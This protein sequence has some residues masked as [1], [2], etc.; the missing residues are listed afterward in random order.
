MQ[1]TKQVKAARAYVA[2]MPGVSRK[3]QIELCRA[4]AN[5]VGI[6]SKLVKIYGP[7]E[8][9]AFVG[10]LRNDEVAVAPDLIVINEKPAP[11]GRRLGVT[12]ERK[13]REMERASL[14]V[15]DAT[16]GLNGKATL[17]SADD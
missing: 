15:L 12:F 1:K 6:A 17:L 5:T 4:A 16:G 10:D 2:A 9:G 14:Y 3:R 11:A 8:W 7:N 13:V